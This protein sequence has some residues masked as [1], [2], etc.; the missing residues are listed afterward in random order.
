M[1]YTSNPQAPRVRR[2]AAQL[3]NN[4]IVDTIFGS[5]DKSRVSSSHVLSAQEDAYIQTA[6]A[7]LQTSL[8]KFLL[9]YQQYEYHTSN[10]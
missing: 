7:L 1:S 5:M 3:V 10:P 2:D 4:D 9:L 8:E 6:E